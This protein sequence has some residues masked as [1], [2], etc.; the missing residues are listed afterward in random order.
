[1]YKIKNTER[2]NEKASDFET[3][4]MLYLLGIRSDRDQIDLVLVDCFNDVTGSDDAVSRLWDVQSKG[5]KSNTPLQ[6]GE[7]LVTLYENFLSDF[8]FKHLILFLETVA[9]IHVTDSN[10]GVFG[11]A[12]F[13]V[14]S[15]G[16]IEKG[17]VREYARRNSILPSEVSTLEIETFLGGVDFVV[18]TKDKITNIKNLI[19]FKNK[20]VRDSDFFVEIFNEI[21]GMQSKLK[22]TNVESSELNNPTDVLSFRK[23]ITRNQIITLL[24]NRLVGIE[25]F[26]NQGIPIDFIPFVVGMDRE[27]TKDLIQSCVAAICRT[28]FDKNNKVNIWRFLEAT[29]KVV[30]KDSTFSVD[31]I[32]G[33]IP[34]QTLKNVPTLDPISIRL[35]ITRIKDGLQ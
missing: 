10:L 27:D 5:H 34:E 32:A 24:V 14:D 11:I 4:S 21:R 7:H 30:M 22:N 19:E 33:Q 12:N 26:S 8:P 35:L 13:T 18:C 6:I 15:R 3:F 28:F 16:K 23:H 1:M 2:N 31:D 25:L 20:D 17:L 9:E 29:I